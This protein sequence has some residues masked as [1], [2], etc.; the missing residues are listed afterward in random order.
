MARDEENAYD[1]EATTQFTQE[2][3]LR[4]LLVG[5]SGAGKS[6]TGNSILGQDFF[7]SRLSAIPVTTVCTVGSCRW[8]RWHVEVLDTPDLF[9]SDIPDTDPRWWERGRCVLLSA[10]GPHV[11]L[12]VTQMGR[13]T[14][15][16]Q[17]AV[18]AVKSMFGE[19]VLARTIVLFTRKEDLEGGSLR[20]YVHGCNN[21]ALRRLVAECGDRMCAFNNRATGHQR[22]KQVAE[23]MAL[24]EQLLRD[25]GGG[26]YTSGPFQL[27]QTSGP[28]S[29]GDQLRL[30]AAD[31]AE[32][33]EKR[34]WRRQ[35]LTRLCAWS[36]APANRLWVGLAVLLGGT[37]LVYL[38]YFRNTKTLEST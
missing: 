36:R 14:T 17:L 37:I 31:L 24:V 38:L 2:P 21:R 20:E 13:F 11:L 25:Q 28:V 5:K 1:P 26:P 9:G 23:L 30:M 22:E 7:L 32:R 33:M 12:L 10:P 19:H 6:A 18:R 16:D 8:G 34:R 27:A 4:L 15:G 35:L 29:S 3:K